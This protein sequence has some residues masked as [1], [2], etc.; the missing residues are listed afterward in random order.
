ME[1]L[2]N[3]S[4]EIIIIFLEGGNIVKNTLKWLLTLSAILVVGLF[5]LSQSNQSSLAETKWDDGVIFTPGTYKASA[6]G[7]HGPVEVEVTVSEDT[8]ESIKVNHEETEGL[9]NVSIDKLVET[10]QNEQ[11][12]AV[13]TVSGASKSTGALIAA[14]TDC[15][16]QAGGNINALKERKNETTA[17]DDEEMEA[18]V[19]VIGGGGAG[20][21]TAVSASEEGASVILIEKNIAVGG[22]TLISGAG[23]NTY[24]P[25]REQNQEITDTL[26]EQLQGYLEDD[27]ANYGDFAPTFEKLQGQIKEYFDSGETYLFDSP[28]LHAIHT[29]IGGKREDKDGKE[30]SGNYDL[31]TTLTNNS[32]DT[33]HWMEDNGVE[34]SDQTSTIL[35]ALWPRSHVLVKGIGEGIV[36][37]FANKAEE[38]GVQILLETRGEELIQEDGKVVGVKASKK[39]GSQLTLKANK[40]VVIATGGF[41]ANPKMRQEYNNYWEDIPL[42][43][44]TTNSPNITGDGIVMAQAVDADTT[45]MEFIQLMPSSQPGTGSLGGGVWGSAEDQVFFNGEGKRFVNEYSERDVLAAAALEQPDQT[46]YIICDEE[47]AGIKDGKNGWGDKVE[48]L[49]ASKSIYK[50]DTLE[51]LAEQIGADPETLV[52]EIDK[53]NSYIDAGEDPDFGKTNF[54]RKI[55]VGPFYATPRSPSVHHTMGG[56]AINSKTQVLDKDGQVIPGLFAVG[57]TTGGIHAGNR[58]GGNAIAD[59]MTFGRIAGK[60]VVK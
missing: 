30:I 58:L 23:F 24:D 29:Y 50:A 55:D 6:E 4:C 57:E 36:T 54:G 42:D 34:F 14:V 40:G 46:F 20:L 33:L 18:D 26:K 44:G 35:G 51:E 32:L 27:P 38:N 3:S 7:N 21:A 31:V 47:T 56:I 17:Q 45:G 59:I 22:N 52:S 2:Y 39:D 43:M 13:D 37:P 48:D 49:I 25:D 10:I 12:L 8:I 15:L 28:E 5:I 19:I 11:T 53:Y 9:G 41:G 1:I 60:E 16:T